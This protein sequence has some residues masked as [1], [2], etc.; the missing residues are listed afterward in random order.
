EAALTDQSVDATRRELRA[1]YNAALDEIGAE[2]IGELKAWPARVEGATAEKYSY[3]V[4]D[5]LVTGEN[6]TESLS[7]NRIPKIAVP[8][9]RDW[10]EILRFI[11]RENLPGAFP[12]TGGV[13]PY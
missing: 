5:R 12:Y 3:K 9:F 10:G 7:Q 4:R 8:K 11:L 6:Y 13:Y 1:A 2:G